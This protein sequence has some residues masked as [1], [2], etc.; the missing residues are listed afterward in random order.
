MI[1]G[2]ILSLSY[3][4]K[5]SK[6]LVSEISFCEGPQKS[7]IIRPEP[8]GSGLRSDFIPF[9]TQTASNTNL[10]PYGG[11]FIDL[12][13][14]I[15]AGLRVFK[16]ETADSRAGMASAKSVSQSSLIAWDAAAASFA[17]A[18]SAPTI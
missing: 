3:D 8:L 2:S 6:N 4:F 7:S 12:T 14:V 5:L 16:A 11:F 17:R 18:S 15:S 1:A 10:T 13:T 9:I